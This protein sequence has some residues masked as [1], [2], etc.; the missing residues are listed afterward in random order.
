MKAFSRLTVVATAV[1]FASPLGLS[2]QALPKAEELFARHVAAVGGKDALSK[3][4]SMKQVG[5]LEIPAMGL[6]ADVENVMAAPNKAATKVTI[7]GLGEI[8]SGCDGTVCWDVNPMQ[9]PRVVVDKELQAR[10]DAADFYGTL[11]FP[12]E[13]FT[14]AQT[15]EITDFGGE[16]A[17]KVKCAL[18]SGR[19]EMM[20]FSVA[21]GLRTGSS[22]TSETPMGVIDVVATASEYKQFGALKVPTKVENSAGPQKFTITFTSVTFD[23][24]QATAFALPDA[25][26]ALV[27]P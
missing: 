1:L 9:G 17:Y 13:R 8:L 24:V 20:Y 18:K 2:A 4:T 22:S 15:I 27:K 3:I 26:K 12:P 23:D 16:K 6:S 21:T 14:S 25:I 7:P 5:K 10:K 19:E 11:L